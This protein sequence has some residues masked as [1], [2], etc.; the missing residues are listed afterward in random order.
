MI[1]MDK[2]TVT[3]HEL[4]EAFEI[5]MRAGADAAIAAF[6]AELD[7]RVA[8]PTPR[9]EAFLKRYRAGSWKSDV[10]QIAQMLTEK[11]K[12]PEF[13]FSDVSEYEDMLR[14]RHPDQRVIMSGVSVTLQSLVRDGALQQVSRGLYRVV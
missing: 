7:R 1:K 2:T 6:R 5:A 12:K 11:R 3:P 10:L 4:A 13:R 9:A 14:E 8:S